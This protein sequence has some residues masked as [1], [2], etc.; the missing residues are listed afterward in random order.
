LIGISELDDVAVEDVKR[1]VEVLR[2]RGAGG[3]T[4]TLEAIPL[5]HVGLGTKTSLLLSLIVAIDIRS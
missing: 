5:Q 4:A 2:A 3:F 1:I